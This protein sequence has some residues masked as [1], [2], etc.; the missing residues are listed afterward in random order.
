MIGYFFSDISCYLLGAIP[1]S[2]VLSKYFLKKD[3]REVGSGNIGTTNAYRAGGAIFAAIIAV[4]DL[5]KGF[6]A[7]RFLM[8]PGFIELFGQQIS[9]SSLALFMVCLGQIFPIFLN[10]RG[11]RGLGVFIGSLMGL[12]FLYGSIIGIF[13]ILLTK[14]AKL[15]FFSSMMALVASVFVFPNDLL[16][17]A[18][19]AIIV[20]RHRENFVQYFQDRKGNG[21]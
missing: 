3:I 15:P 7:V 5:A 6:I 2:V 9:T 8:P 1:F 10:F 19:I 13:W 21:K 14:V 4:L 12:N 17:L 16:K 20:V 11:G 18:I